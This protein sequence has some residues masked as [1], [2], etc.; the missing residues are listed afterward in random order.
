MA[1]ESA[2][3]QASRDSS[4]RSKLA[5]NRGDMPSRPATEYTSKPRLARTRVRARLS[6]PASNNIAL[7]ND[8]LV[9]SDRFDITAPGSSQ[10]CSSYPVSTSASPLER[11]L[12]LE[13]PPYDAPTRTWNKRHC[14]PQMCEDT[15]EGPNLTFSNDSLSVFVARVLGQ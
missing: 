15:K 13:V 4:G 12:Q 14:N 2:R 9:C 8:I 1:R 5:K 3:Q 11:R 10:S 7:N 6:D